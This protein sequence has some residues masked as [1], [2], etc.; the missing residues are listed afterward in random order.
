[1]N[2]QNQ[3]K[4]YTVSLIQVSLC[5]EQR[6]V[7][8]PFWR[9]ANCSE[10]SWAEEVTLVTACAEESACVALAGQRGLP[11]CFDPDCS[12][13][14][15]AS[16]GVCILSSQVCCGPFFDCFPLVLTPGGACCFWFVSLGLLWVLSISCPLNV[17]NK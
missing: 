10:S 11:A 7:S 5:L 13:Y 4:D 1:M 3:T 15:T 12:D 2:C 9:S 17:L 8:S 14:R 6:L 16:L